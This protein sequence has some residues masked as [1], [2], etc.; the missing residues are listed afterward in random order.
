M[1]KAKRG[2]DGRNKKGLRAFLP[3]RLPMPS[4]KGGTMWFL[5]PFGLL[6]T[7]IGVRNV[8]GFQPDWSVGIPA[9]VAA[10]FLI[11]LSFPKKAKTQAYLA[12]LPIPEKG[13]ASARKGKGSKPKGLKPIPSLEWAGLLGVLFLGI[14][15]MNVGALA[16]GWVLAIGVAGRAFWLRKRFGLVVGAPQD[17]PLPETKV[18]FGVLVV[19]ALLRFPWLKSDF[20][21]LQGDEVSNLSDTWGIVYWHFTK[22][23]P[24]HT[25]WG[26]TPNLPKVIVALFYSVL[27]SD[28]WVARLVSA[29]ASMV[30]LWYFKKWCRF[31]FGNLAS[32]V[33]TL[34]MGISWWFLYFS[35]SPFHNGIL[36]MTE[37]MAFYYLEK[38]FREGKRWDFWWS[39]VLAAACVINYVPGRGVPV[40]MG[41]TV[42]A[43]LFLF[44]VQFLKDYWKQ[45]VLWFLAFVWLVSPF[46]LYGMDYPGEV[47]G[48]VLTGWIGE[49]AKR[50]GSYFFILKTYFWTLSTLFTPNS[51]VDARFAFFRPFLDLFS[52]ALF[53]LGL[54]I[55]L[56]NLR[57]AVAWV[58]LPGLLIAV[59]ANALG[60]QA[61]PTQVGYVHSVRLST[62][63]PFV[64]LAGSWGLEWLLGF[65]RR[66][67]SARW[68]WGAVLIGLGVTLATADNLPRIFKDFRYSH[69]AWGER[70]FDRLGMGQ[71]L[72]DHYPQDHIWVEAAIPDSIVTYL[73]IGHVEEKVFS[74]DPPMPIPYKVH[75]DVFMVFQ[76]NRLTAK[77]IAKIKET[78]PKAQWTDYKSPWDEVYLTSVTVPL[79]DI[80]SSQKGME[81]KE[82]MP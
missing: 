60:I 53:L 50:T 27:G 16:L 80:L 51:S 47:W 25:G 73:N 46:I 28:V 81:L 43:Y 65:Y 31:W 64:F 79:A 29:L 33:A 41:L 62:V 74:F 59:S 1:A 70:G 38:G 20:T 13:V 67:S 21:G 15:C 7:W 77:G 69:G 9:L 34:L 14:W 82:E 23:N 36:M 17:Y 5:L 42:L 68:G 45:M 78:Y 37:V 56:L 26:G 6:A 44:R 49:E 35:F 2:R 66:T 63:I 24:F 76:S 55:A 10:C 54:S 61:S 32:L 40:M 12:Q 39:G 48:R 4:F 57:R 8:V 72:R 58:L 11:V 18:F 75:K 71:V 22:I 52:G 3:K 19:L 30:T